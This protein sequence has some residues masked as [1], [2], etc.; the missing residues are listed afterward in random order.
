MAGMS[1]EGPATGSGTNGL[2]PRERLIDAFMALLAER[3]FERIDIKDIAERAGV[4]LVDFRAEFGSTFDILSAF[5]KKIDRQV[6]AG[7]EQPDADSTPRERLFDVLMKRFE[8]LVPYRKA[9]ANLRP[10]AFAMPQLGIALSQITLRSMQWMLAGAGLES[11]GM[12]G[13]VRAQGLAVLFARVFETW[14]DDS[15]PGLARTMAKLDRELSKAAT[16]SSRFEELCN[17][18]PRLPRGRR[19][20]RHR[21]HDWGGDHPDTSRPGDESMPAAA[22]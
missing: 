19:F 6:L 8:L 17:F 15:D 18:L 1:G 7:L 21:R 11:A 12:R 9:L 10:S 14:L 16:W 5:A 3:R 22:I 20:R 2:S 4:P 13:M